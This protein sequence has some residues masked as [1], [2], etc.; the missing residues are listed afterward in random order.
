MEINISALILTHARQAILLSA[1]SGRDEIIFPYGT[2]I[3]HIIM[4]KD[5][6]SFYVYPPQNTSNQSQ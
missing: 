2:D 6:V 4:L 3:L 5:N 1:C